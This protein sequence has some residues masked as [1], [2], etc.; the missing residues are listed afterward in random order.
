MPGETWSS[1]TAYLTIFE[2]ALIELSRYCRV[3]LRDTSQR[4]NVAMATAAYHSHTRTVHIHT[5]VPYLGKL[6]SRVV[7]ASSMHI[8]YVR[9][10]AWKYFY[11]KSSSKNISLKFL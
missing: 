7:V 9:Q 10:E 5:K 11:L 2:E 3:P 8:I 1:D 4:P 6:S